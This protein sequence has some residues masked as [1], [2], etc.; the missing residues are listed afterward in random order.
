MDMNK[1]S[2][3]AAYQW[4]GMQLFLSQVFVSVHCSLAIRPKHLLYIR[5]R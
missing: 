2:M 3:F 5:Q 1:H 4:G